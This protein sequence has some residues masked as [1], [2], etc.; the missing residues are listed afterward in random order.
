MQI[1]RTLYVYI[2]IY[3][4]TNIAIEL[5]LLNPMSFIIVIIYRFS[6]NFFLETI[7][8]KIYWNRV[9]ITVKVEF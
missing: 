3:I 4:Y 1:Y 8:E 9:R 7:M 5:V 2:A 6:V